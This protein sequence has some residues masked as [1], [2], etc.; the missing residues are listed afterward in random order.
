MGLASA[1]SPMYIAEVAPARLRGQL[2]LMN[3]LAIV[4]GSVMAMLVAYLLSSGEHWRWMF[5]SQ[6]VPVLCLAMGLLFVP[7]SPRWLAMIGKP[8]AALRVLARINGRS[9]AEKEMKNIQAEWARKSAASPS[10]GATGV[11]VALILGIVLMIFAQINGANPILGYAALM[12]QEAGVSAPADAILNQLYV[13]GWIGICTLVAFW[14][15]D[16]FG[17]RSIL[18]VGCLGI[19]FGHLLMFLSYVCH[20]PP[21]LML[22]AML[23]PTGAY[24]LTLSL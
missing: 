14:L 11:R 20:W 7:E 16:K 4:V 8:R 15:T 1:V 21:V 23:V 24:T 17:R 10:C 22:L 19:A 6:V 18:I 12:F 9:Q 3:Q 2:V 13:F 5:A